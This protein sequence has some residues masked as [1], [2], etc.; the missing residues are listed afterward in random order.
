M[1]RF[2]FL[3]LT[4]LFTLVSGFIS[5]AYAHSVQ[6]AYCVSCNGDLRIFVEHWHGTESLSSTTMTISLTI[7]NVT[8]TQTQSP[9]T[10]IYNTTLANL[11]GCTSPITVAAACAGQANTYNNW[12]VFDYT[13]ITCGVPCSFTITSGNTVFTQDG[14][15]MYPLTVNF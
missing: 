12:V 3:S 5:K 11:P 7:N 9:Q 6:V 15:G 4:V 1:N 13:G 2:Y 8:T 14:C 10:G